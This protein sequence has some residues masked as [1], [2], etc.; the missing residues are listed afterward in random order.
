MLRK[1]IV[2]IGCIMLA[3]CATTDNGVRVSQ[4][5]PKPAPVVPVQARTEPIFYNGK[6]YTLKFAPAAAGGYDVAVLGMSAKQKTD[7]TNIA[8]SAIRYFTC[9]DGKTGKLTS[10]PRYEADTWK[11]GARC[12]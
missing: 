4:D 12:G 1:I 7:A 6:T 10:A 8:T 3:G 2:A 5:K 9:P 11:M